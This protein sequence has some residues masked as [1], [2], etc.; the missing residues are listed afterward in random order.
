MAPAIWLVTESTLPSGMGRH[1]LELGRG[2]RSRAAMSI[3]APPGPGARWLLDE[4]KAAGLGAL[5]LGEAM[6]ERMPD[7][8]HVHAG[9][10]W[11]GIEATRAAR[12]AGVRVVVRTEHLPDLIT[13]PAE[14]AAHTQ[15][16]HAV[17]RVICVSP[18]VAASH[19]AAGVPDSLIRIVPN[20]LDPVRPRE[21]PSAVRAALGVPVG[22][23]LAVSVGRFT[24]QKGY[25]VLLAAVPRIL[26]AVPG[27][28]FVWV[29]DGPLRGDVVQGV[30][31]AGLEEAVQV[32][33]AY[34]DIPALLAAAD[35]V[36]APSRFEGLSMVVLEAMAAGRTVVGSRV[37]G[38]EEAVVDRGT[39][40][41]V[42]P[43]DPAALAVGVIDALRDPARRAAWGAAARA[44]QRARF[45]ARLMA[46]RTL[47]VYEEA[48]AGAARPLAGAVR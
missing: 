6:S 36:I 44:R 33:A 13:D 9:I 15:S 24:P 41:L 27:I 10:G 30:R 40:R 18:G 5:A 3:V 16:L 7:L 28:R 35:V 47:A 32:L 26:S 19:R 23:P 39:G 22:G 8:V 31:G 21:S 20:G 1:M 12:D 43:E 37:V 17:D 46:D 2:L 45:G 38:I 34:R 11:E 14:R 48:L 42:P 29:G 4:A 25:D